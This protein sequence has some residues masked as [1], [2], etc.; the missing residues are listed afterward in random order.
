MNGE[1]DNQQLLNVFLE[2]FAHNQPLEWFNGEIKDVFGPDV[3]DHPFKK[4]R[5][6]QIIRSGNIDLLLLK[7]EQLNACYQQ[8][9]QEFL[10]VDIPEL[11]NTHV[12][13]LDPA[14]PMYADFVK[15]TSFPEHYLDRMYSSDFAQHFYSEDEISVFRDKWSGSHL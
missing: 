11:K 1:I 4:Q 10:G 7:L 12:T 5:G 8:A 3:F 2:K 15:N 13:E 14:K 9:F 6:Y